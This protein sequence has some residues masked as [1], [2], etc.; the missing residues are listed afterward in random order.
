MMN[1]VKYLALIIVIVLSICI[2]TQDSFSP[3]WVKTYGGSNTELS[4]HYSLQQTVDGGYIVA[5][6]TYSFGAGG[7]GVSPNISV[8]KLTG[9]SSSS[10]S[11]GAGVTTGVTG[12][13]TNSQSATGVV[14]GAL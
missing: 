1:K 13:F 11:T 10:N 12:S 6:Q 7:F 14:L 3:Q 8:N 2:I 9:A 4:E 5:G